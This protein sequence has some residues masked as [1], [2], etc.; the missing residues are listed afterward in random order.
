[1]NTTAIGTMTEYTYICDDCGTENGLAPAVVELCS[2]HWTD[3][4]ECGSRWKFN[5][6]GKP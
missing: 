4:D 3:C 1:M 6:S 2:E 5:L